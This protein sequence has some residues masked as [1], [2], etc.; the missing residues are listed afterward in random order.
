MNPRLRKLRSMNHENVNPAMTNTMDPTRPM[1]ISSTG[2]GLPASTWRIASN[3]RVLG[4]IL[5]IGCSTAGNDSIG[6]KAPDSAIKMKLLPH[7]MISAPCPNR[8]TAPMPAMP[9]PQPTI[10]K[11]S[12]IGTND[13]PTAVV[14]KPK[15]TYAVIDTTINAATTLA[16]PRMAVPAM[17]SNSVT[18][19]VSTFMRLRLHVSSM[20]PVATAIWLWKSTWNI[21]APPIRNGAD[22]WLEASCWATYVPRLPHR[23]T[24][25]TGQKAMSNQRCGARQST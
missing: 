11:I 17:Y 14:S 4:R 21:I 2:N 16:M 7:V 20:K 25:I 23:I 19:V 22:A 6:L 15:N 9:S 13:H 24:S 8:S 12:E 3:A 10:I 1:T 5:E 18:G